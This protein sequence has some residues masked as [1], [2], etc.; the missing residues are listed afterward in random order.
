MGRRSD[1]SRTEL[2]ALFLAAGEAHMAE[3]GFARFSAREVAK[4]VGY[5]VGTLYNVFGSYDRFVLAINTRTLLGWTQALEDRLSGAGP[6]RIGALVN[7]YF[8]FAEANPNRWMALYDH[9]MPPGEEVT[10]R[11]N[12]AFGGLIGI[13][14]RE[15]AAVLGSPVDAV[16]HALTG[17]L[18]AIVHGHCTFA[19]NGT[20]RSFGGDPRAAA[21]ARI[22][23]ALTVT[24]Y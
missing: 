4:R 9:R 17:S 2:E 23:A 16:T 12:Q 10:E 21:L 8:D 18:V 11:F 14:E 15:V 7:G 22:R 19:L 13:I 24:H 1:H 3:A 6:D 5:S 20:Y